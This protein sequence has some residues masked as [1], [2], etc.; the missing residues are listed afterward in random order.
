MKQKHIGLGTDDT[1]RDEW[2]TQVHRDTYNSL[3]GHS[4]LLQY[5]ALSGPTRNKAETR[6]AMV[7]RMC[8]G[9]ATRRAPA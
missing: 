6:L 4:A 2:L 3:L 1:S 8:G 7:S 5:A 9:P